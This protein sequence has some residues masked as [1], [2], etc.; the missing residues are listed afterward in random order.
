MPSSYP[1][2]HMSL[3]KLEPSTSGKRWVSV[4]NWA[5]PVG[6]DLRNPFPVF[7]VVKNLIGLYK[8]RRL[9]DRSCLERYSLLMSGSEDRLLILGIQRGFTLWACAYLICFSFL[10]FLLLTVLCIVSSDC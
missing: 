5:T 4:V 6:S 3:P 10:E 7:L 1:G 8:P 2:R 9:Q